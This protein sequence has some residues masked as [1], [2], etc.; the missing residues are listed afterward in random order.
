MKLWLLMI[1]VICLGQ[2]GH[3][4]SVSQTLREAQ[5]ILTVNPPSNGDSQKFKNRGQFELKLLKI[6]EKIESLGKFIHMVGVH[7]ENFGRNAVRRAGF[8][9]LAEQGG[10]MTGDDMMGWGEWTIIGVVLIATI[11]VVVW[12]MCLCLKFRKDQ[13]EGNFTYTRAWA[14]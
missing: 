4:R 7:S 10:E 3:V 5:G 8:M 2:M 9:G 11:V 1:F 12:L 14:Y 6:K 13:R